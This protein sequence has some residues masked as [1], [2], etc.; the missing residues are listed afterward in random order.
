MRVNLSRSA[1]FC[2]GVKRAVDMALESAGQEENIYMLGDIVHNEFVVKRIKEKGIKKIRKLGK[3]EGKTLLIRAHGAP[4][5]LYEDAEGAGYK[6]IDATCPMVKGIHRLARR[7]RAKGRD[8]II[9]G[10]S[11]HDEVLGIKGSV[12][13]DPLIIDPGRELPEKKIKKIE[14]ASALVQSTQNSKTVLGI[15]DLL[16]E[17]IEDFCFFDTVC[18]PT[19]SRQK[20]AHTIPVRNQA[21]L[22]IG[23]KSSANTKRLYEISRSL[24]SRT[25]W[26]SSPDEIDPDFFKGARTVGVLAGASTPQEIIHDAVCRLELL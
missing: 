2:M 13:G 1:G 15:V 22:V 14:K 4:L 8:I 9:I 7:E 3:G 6:I 25:L 16:S 5:S 17:M 12:D 10:D 21:V 20:D 23:S 24:N 11:L 26:V 19:K 18:Q